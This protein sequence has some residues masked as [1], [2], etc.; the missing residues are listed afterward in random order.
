MALVAAFT[1]ADS[2]LVVTLFFSNQLPEIAHAANEVSLIVFY[3][4]VMHL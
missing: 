1:P 2:A 4:S 3:L